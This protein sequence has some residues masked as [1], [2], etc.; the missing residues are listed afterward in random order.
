MSCCGTYADVSLFSIG[1]RIEIEG[2]C[3]QALIQRGVLIMNG[4]LIGTRVL[5][6]VKM[7]WQ[8]AIFPSTANHLP[9]SSHWTSP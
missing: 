7:C 1:A 3:Q 2:A 9:L 4:A 8:A 6:P 5:S